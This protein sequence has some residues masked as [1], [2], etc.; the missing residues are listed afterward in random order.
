MP[1]Y[2]ALCEIPKSQ[3][4]HKL[5]QTDTGNGLCHCW[6]SI[7]TESDSA[8]FIFRINNYYRRFLPNLTTTLAPLHRLLTKNLPG[9]GNLSNKRFSK[10]EVTIDVP[11][12]LVHFDDPYRELVLAC[13]SCALMPHG[14]WLWKA[15]RISSHLL[16]PTERKYAQINKEAL[17]CIFG[18]RKFHNYLF[19]CHF[20]V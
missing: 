13:W 2:E 1:L 11:C 16:A 20:K 7:P 4:L 12:Q 9:P 14:G 10:G 6:S 5:T 3:N 19:G 17:A 18:V 15:Y 8:P